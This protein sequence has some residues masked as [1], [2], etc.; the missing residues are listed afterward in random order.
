MN[1]W[2]HNYQKEVSNVAFD[3]LKYTVKY[4]LHAVLQIHVQ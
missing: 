1:E 3:M 4:G 2:K